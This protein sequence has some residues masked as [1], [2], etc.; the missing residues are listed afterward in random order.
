MADRHIDLDAARRARHEVKGTHLT[1]VLGGQQFT[2]PSE[3][4]WEFVEHIYRGKVVESLQL[5]FGDEQWT[6]FRAAGPSRD[7]INELTDQIFDLYGLGTAG[8]PP[9]SGSSSTTTSS[10]SRPTSPASTG[11]TSDRPSGAR[12][13]TKS[14]PGASAA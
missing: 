10:S 4:P 11:S 14:G 6:A 3:A 12:R 13:R 1:V 5:L 7:D 8:E 9:A 2:L